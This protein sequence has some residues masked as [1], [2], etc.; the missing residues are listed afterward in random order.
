[1]TG[2]ERPTGLYRDPGTRGF[3]VTDLHDLPEDG[4]RYELIDGS[5]IVSPSATMG[6]NTVA[7]WI[8]TR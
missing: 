7:R 4:P 8:A 6:H 1:M 3:T 5:I 2:A